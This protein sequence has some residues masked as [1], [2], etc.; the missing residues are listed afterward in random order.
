MQSII[1]RR[2]EISPHFD[3]WVRGDRFAVVID[4]DGCSGV[5]LLYKLRFDKSHDVATFADTNFRVVSCTCG[6]PARRDD[7]KYS[8]CCVNW[9]LCGG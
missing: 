8:L 5:A 6:A 7:T 3:R 1:G 9:P 2:V 4:H